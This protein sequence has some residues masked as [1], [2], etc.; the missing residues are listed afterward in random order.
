MLLARTFASFVG[1]IDESVKQL[2]ADPDRDLFVSLPKE[3]DLAVM[4]RFASYLPGWEMPKNSSSFPN[5][6]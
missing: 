4:D 6:K 1:N 3:L 5:E 2:V